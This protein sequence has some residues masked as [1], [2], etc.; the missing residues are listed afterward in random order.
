M[1][2]EVL[3]FKAL[4]LAGV[5]ARKYREDQPRVPEGNPDGGQWTYDGGSSSQSG[6][7]ESDGDGGGDRRIEYESDAA[8]SQQVAQLYERSYLLSERVTA[9]G[10]LCRYVSSFGVVE[11]PGSLSLGC[12]SRPLSS[13]VSH[14]RRL[15]LNDNMRKMGMIYD[16]TR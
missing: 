3:H 1:P 2:D 11:G 13:A 12:E 9:D 14:Y 15:P 10:R 4:A 5:Y 6:G 7:E 16:H 8:R